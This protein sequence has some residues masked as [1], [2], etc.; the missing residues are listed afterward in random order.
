MSDMSSFLFP[1][2][3]YYGKVTPEALAFNANLQE[4][5]TKVNYISA[6]ATNGKITL[7]K[8][9]TDIEEL[10]EELENSKKQL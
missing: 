7:A 8:A 5:A 2:S 4:F 10:W 1:Q 3:R 6:L 9:W